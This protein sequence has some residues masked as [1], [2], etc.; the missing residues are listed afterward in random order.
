MPDIAAHVFVCV[1]FF[2]VCMCMCVCVSIC[3][4]GQTHACGCVGFFFFVTVQRCPKG[5]FPFSHYK[6]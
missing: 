6:C 2:N 1:F 4:R 3:V 5:F